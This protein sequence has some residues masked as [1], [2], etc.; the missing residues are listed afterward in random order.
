MQ[1]L[2]NPF[3]PQSRSRPHHPSPRCRDISPRPHPVT[4]SIRTM[5]DPSRIGAP[6][7]RPT[8]IRLLRSP[9]CSS[10]SSRITNR[11]IPLLQPTRPL[12]SLSSIATSN[13]EAALTVSQRILKMEGTSSSGE[14]FSSLFQI[15]NPYKVDW[16]L[17]TTLIRSLDTY[18]Q[19]STW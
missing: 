4:L 2:L 14:H 17:Y 16:K 19:S 7:P 15:C 12:H 18:F 9:L 1:Q 10:P 6:C 3:R 8:S 13:T 5:L 11:P